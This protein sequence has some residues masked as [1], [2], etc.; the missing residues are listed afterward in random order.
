MLKVVF[1]LHAAAG[2]KSVGDADGGGV[3][4][5]RPDVELIILL[6][7]TAVNDVEDVLPVFV[8]VFRRKL[9]GDLFKLIRKVAA[10]NV[11]PLLQCRRYRVPIFLLVLPQLGSGV[12]FAAGIGH[13]EHIAQKRPVSAVVD[14]GDARSAPPYIP[15]HPLVPEII[16]RAGGGIGPLGVDQ[17][18]F[19]VRIFIE[20][21]RCGE[22]GRPFLIAT[23]D[24]VGGVVGQLRVSLDLTRH[25]QGPPSQSP[26]TGQ[27][28]QS[29]RPSCA[30]AWQGRC[31]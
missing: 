7:K 15:A 6:Q 21:A 30:P 17:E 22:K 27:G 31:Q 28:Q 4:E 12:L 29:P 18:L 9:S 13:I 20:T 24:L 19:R 10:G 3:S 25:R 11:K 26:G 5:L 1:R 14:N 2:H 8:P 16:F 23:G